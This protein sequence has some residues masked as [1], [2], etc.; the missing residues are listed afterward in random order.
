MKK[1]IYFILVF[2]FLMITGCKETPQLS[3]DL[4]FDAIEA[5]LNESIPNVINSNVNLITEN[6]NYGAI[7]SWKSSKEEIL[8]SKGEFK[9]DTLETFDVILSYIIEIKGITR[10]GQIEVKVEPSELNL[11]FNDI[12]KIIRSKIPTSTN[13]DLELMYEYYKYSAKI[14]WESSNENVISSKGVVTNY[15][16]NPVS[17]ILT[18]FARIISP[19]H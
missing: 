8:S 2:L 3:Y 12:E 16:T 13:K 19:F 4:Y 17:V 10:E 11:K 18:L 5:E 1:I 14:T 9:N 6:Y 15:D 7:I